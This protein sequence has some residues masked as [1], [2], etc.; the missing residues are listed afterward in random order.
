[1][2]GGVEPE[3]MLISNDGESI[4][5]TKDIAGKPC[6]D[7]QALMRRYDVI[8]EICDNMI[9]LGGVHIKMIM[10]TLMVNLK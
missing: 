1:M 4:S 2:M 10:K 6:Y 9:S 5:D 8:S 3:F 7:Q